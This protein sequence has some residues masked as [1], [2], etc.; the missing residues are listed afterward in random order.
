MR[1]SPTTGTILGGIGGV[2]VKLSLDGATPAALSGTSIGGAWGWLTNDIVAGQGDTS[3]GTGPYT[4]LKYVISTLTRS[5]LDA[6]P[7]GENDA[8][9]NFR[10]GNSEWA[11]FMTAGALKG[12][13]SATV[14]FAGGTTA[15]TCKVLPLAGLGDIDENGQ[16]YVIQNFASDAGIVCYTG[17]G[18]KLWTNATSVLDGSNR[19]RARNGTVAY[20]D[21]ASQWHLASTVTGLSQAFAPRTDEIV[22]QMCPVT[23]NGATWVAELTSTKLTIRP[24][25]SSNGYIVATSP[26]L[27]NIDAISL[28]AG[29]V[30]V[31]WSVTT[32]EA[33]TDLRIAD[34]NIGTGGLSTGTT[35]SGALV[36][37]PQSPLSASAF[38]VG[39]VE[40]G[41][42]AATKQPRY[43]IKSD[44]FVGGDDG[45]RIYQKYWDLISTQAAAAPN[46]SQATGTISPAQGGTGTTTGLTTLDGGNLIAGTVTTSA[47]A[48]MFAPSELVPPVSLVVAAN[49]SAVVNRSLTLGTTVGVTLQSGA[50]LRIL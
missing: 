23:I 39:P 27:F 30:R 16:V 14:P 10:A 20:E 42:T 6:T 8:S 34:L 49:I 13:R 41:T 26:N 50:R 29:T 46:L 4:L 18:S 7:T 36:I 5:T 37:T 28:S 21:T 12:V 44:A 15:G 48:P 40:G 45:K 3:G 32:G 19:L 47:L 31:G 35:T 25:T 24:A 9:Q 22:A 1:L 43:A 38:T 33:N 2:G 11:A 17:S